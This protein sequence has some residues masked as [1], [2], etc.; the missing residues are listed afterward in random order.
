MS[1][2]DPDKIRS[3]VPVI[4]DYDRPCLG[5]GYNLV[6]LKT[7]GVCPE[8]GRKI[9]IRQK[10]VARYSDNI[11]NAP[12]GWL[13]GLAMGSTLMFLASLGMFAAFVAAA[14]AASAAPG[15]PVIAGIIACVWYVGVWMSTRP[16]PRMKL[17]KMDPRRE[18]RGMRA[19]A[20]ASQA[21]W[22][23]TAGFLLAG[24]RGPGAGMGLFLWLGVTSFAVAVLGMIPLFALLSNIAYWG[25]DSNLADRFRA[26]AW[27][28]GFTATLILLHIINVLTHAILMGGFWASMIVVLLIFFVIAPFFYVMFC[29]FQFQGMARWAMLNHATAEAKEQRMRDKA[30]REA[31]NRA[32][33]PPGS[34]DGVDLS[35][36]GLGDST[37]DEA[38][39]TGVRRTE[40]HRVERPAKTDRARPGQV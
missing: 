2:V 1:P 38:K 15:V 10:D 26:C 21:G 39:Q 32:P 8:C 20:R 13:R 36:F 27:L 24:A 12:L 7:D 33:P 40:G 16:R 6:G 11:V 37:V 3:T 30:M 29:C 31:A 9:V 23:L 14:L 35:T 18:W 25:S 17:M 22:V 28:I 34:I 4:I 19:A 5:C